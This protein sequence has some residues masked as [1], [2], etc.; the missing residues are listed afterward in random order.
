MEDP[1]G[2]NRGKQVEEYLASTNTPPG[3]YWSAAFIYWCFSKAAKELGRS[4][5]VYKTAGCLDHWNNTRGKKFTKDQAI[6]DPSLIK[7]GSIFIKNHGGGLGTIP[8]LSSL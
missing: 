2:S 3:N 7:P 8:A 6:N 1:P 5:P 4:N